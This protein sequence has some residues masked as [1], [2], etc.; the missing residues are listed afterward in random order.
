VEPSIGG[1]PSGAWWYRIVR[2]ACQQA[3]FSP[4]ADL[5]SDDYIAIQSLVAAGLGVSVIPGLAATHL[6]S[7]V[8]VRQL[9]SAAPL[10]RISAMWPK[11]DCCTGVSVLLTYIAMDTPRR[12]PRCQISIYVLT[13]TGITSY[14]QTRVGRRMH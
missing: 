1:A 3:T 5:A 4:Q 11:Y 8:A 13:K 2:H 14:G 6:L 7:G 10:R 12:R 9:A